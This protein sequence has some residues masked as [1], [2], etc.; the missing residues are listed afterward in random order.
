MTVSE[1]KTTDFDSLYAEYGAQVYQLCLKYSERDHH[2][3][4]DAKQHTF[5]KL[6]MEMEKDIEITNM[7]SYLH[8]IL[9]NYITNS[10]VK[11]NR[12][13]LTDESA[14]SEIIEWN[15][16]EPSA[17]EKYLDATSN[18][19]RGQL[20]KSLLTEM[21]DYNQTWHTIIV[22]VYYRE[23]SQT[24][25]AEELGISDTAMYATMKRIRRWSNKH[26]LR[27][28]LDIHNQSKEVP[29]GTS[30]TKHDE[31]TH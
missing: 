28:E 24:E 19:E 3:A 30:F 25:V 9:R 26:R 12:E 1:K 13:F 7:S 20:L 14:D 2:L 10:R 15:E 16:H 23:R 29:K 6:Y 17:E 5:M 18:S 4:E 8:T 27:I 31:S 11:G 22:E 21:K